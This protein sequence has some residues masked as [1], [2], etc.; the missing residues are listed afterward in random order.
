[1]RAPSAASAEA[2]HSPIPRPAPVTIA[3]SPANRMSQSPG[4][5]F[6]RQRKLKLILSRLHG[7]LARM[8]LVAARQCRIYNA[9]GK[10]R[11][12]FFDFVGRH[13]RFIFSRKRWTPATWHFERNPMRAGD[14]SRLGRNADGG[15]RER[16]V[17]GNF[18]ASL[19]AGIAALATGSLGIVDRSKNHDAS[20]GRLSLAAGH[21]A[22]NWHQRVRI[23]L[24]AD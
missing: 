11:L 18:T 24:A 6:G 5:L 4:R 13:I 3:T 16:A 2:I 14:R 21:G 1:M 22:S 9:A 10:L 19:A 12:V 20:R 8:N 7:H 17:G 23:T 15:K